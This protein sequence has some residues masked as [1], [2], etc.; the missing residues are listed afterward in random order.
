M[1][2]TLLTHP[3]GA[4]KDD[5]L[6]I[7]LLAAK[8]GAPVVRRMP[9]P[10]DLAD[11]GVAIVDVGGEHAPERNNFDHHHLP[12]EHAPTCALSLV[13][14]HLGLYEDGLR[15][16]PWLETAEWFDARGPNRTAEHLG[17]PRR[18]MDQLSS[19]VDGTLMRHFSRCAT[20]SPDEPLY[21]FM[22]L[23]G[24]DLL[25]E[26]AAIRVRLDHVRTH[27][28][29]WSI[30]VGDEVIEALFL[31]RRDPLPDEASGAV[32]AY[33]ELNGLADTIAVI[34]YPDRRGSGYGLQRYED[35][36]RLDFALVEGEV[37]VHFAHTTGFLCKTTATT[38]E[39]L[40]ALVTL[41]WLP[42]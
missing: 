34:V 29:R 13:L 20:L 28:V 14:A 42:V 11:P 39:R 35:H 18:V 31:P 33:I 25:D 36:P 16:L 6:A 15:F 23:V 32:Q 12:R 2:H 9:S 17:V 10:E 37:D 41:A 8:T 7:C 22:R 19:P 5:V 3:G 4:H 21:A 1:I 27:G 24:Q 26:L 38:P 30:P 40:Q